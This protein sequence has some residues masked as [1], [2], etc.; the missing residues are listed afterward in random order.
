MAPVF[1]PGSSDTFFWHLETL[2]K[3]WKK[4]LGGGNSGVQRCHPDENHQ[5]ALVV[6]DSPIHSHRKFNHVPRNM[7]G[8][9]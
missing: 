1:P 9:H 6:D 4:S 5:Q 3:S 7:G 2:S 8:D